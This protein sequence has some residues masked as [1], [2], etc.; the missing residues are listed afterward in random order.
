LQNVNGFTVSTSPRP[1]AAVLRQAFLGTKSRARAAPGAPAR[2]LIGINSLQDGR[3]QPANLERIPE[4]EAA[5]LQ[6]FEVAPGDVLV[7][8]K[9]SALKAALIGEAEAGLLASANL[10]VLRPD[11]AQVAPEVLYA[12]VDSPPFQARAWS[13]STASAGL[14]SLSVKALG[15]IEIPLPVREAQAPLA[16]LIAAAEAGYQ[17]AIEAAQARRQLAHALVR[18]ALHAGGDSSE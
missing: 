18:Q 11:P 17:A 4:D 12:C 6:R 14:L 3:I 13:L 2:G 16:A 15:T 5:G 1:L 8:A 9:G 10:I 7:T